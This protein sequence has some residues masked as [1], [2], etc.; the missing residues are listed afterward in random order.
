MRF[1]TKQQIEGSYTGRHRSRQQGGSTEFVDYREYSPG[2]D[3]RRLDWKVLGRTER[4]VVRLYQDET[5]L[6][7]TLA[8]DAS[9]SMRFGSHR[10]STKLEYAQSLATGMSHVIGR[11]Q[12]QVG[13]AV[14]AGGLRDV[15]PPGGT[16]GHLHRV[17][18]AIESLKTEPATDLAGSLHDLFGRLTRRGVLAVFS[19][20]LVDDLEKTFASI[21]LFRHRRW[22]VILLHLVHPDEERL[23]E[24][25]AYRFEGME[26]D[27]AIACSPAEIRQ[28][29]EKKF[30]DYASSVRSLALAA[31]CD[32]RRISTAVPYMQTLGGFLVERSG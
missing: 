4:Q 8:I 27:G 1:A 10:G 15:L 16:P 14:L 21:R 22:E 26:N 23:P 5:N 7:C 31:G 3:L 20:F 18:G 29:Y 32:Y 25:L 19:D 9:E 24:G 17:Q 2:E 6:V 28:E 30:E 12:D 13:L 11:Q